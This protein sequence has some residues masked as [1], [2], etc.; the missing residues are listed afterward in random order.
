MRGPG[1]P[2]VGL[3]DHQPPVNQV[4][5]TW[6]PDRQSRRMALWNFMRGSSV[7]PQ[8]WGIGVRPA[9]SGASSSENVKSTAWMAP[10]QM[11][12]GATTPITQPAILNVTRNLSY[13]ATSDQV[14]PPWMSYLGQ[15]EQGIPAGWRG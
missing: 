8:S 12:R 11:F 3:V 10:Q 6:G 14:G 15:L 9:P 13:P 4:V 5:Q 7:G 2:V 1:M